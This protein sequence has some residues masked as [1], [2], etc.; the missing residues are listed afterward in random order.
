MQV[1]REDLHMQADEGQAKTNL[2]QVGNDFTPFHSGIVIFVNQQRFNNH[3]DLK[4][5]TVSKV[6]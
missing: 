1:H 4:E 6:I 2:G 3:K 5:G